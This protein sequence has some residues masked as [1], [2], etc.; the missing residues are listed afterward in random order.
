[1]ES[2]TPSMTAIKRKTLSYLQPVVMSVLLIAGGAGGPLVFA[3]GLRLAELQ[4]N[5]PA[6]ERSEEFAS[7]VRFDHVRQIK[8]E[9]RRSAI[10]FDIPACSQL[11][12]TQNRVLFA[13][14]GHRL[15]NGLLAPLTC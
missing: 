13:P 8:L 3:P 12:H 7:V 4:E 9:R 5:M 14:G 10:I 15:S 11:G 6:N 1:M 2:D